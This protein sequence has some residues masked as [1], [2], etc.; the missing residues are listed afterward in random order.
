MDDVLKR[1]E[2][3]RREFDALR[4]S[5]TEQLPTDLQ[6]AYDIEITYASNAIEG[7]SLTLGET[8]E[9]IEHGTTTGNKKLKD[10]LEATDHFEAVQ[11]MRGFAAT[12]GAINEEAV[13]ELHRLTMVRSRAD[14]AGMYARQRRRVAGSPMVF[15]NW[16]KVPDLVKDFGDRIS[17]ANGAPA[18]AFDAHSRLVTIHPFSDGNGRTARLLANLMLI[19]NGYVTVSV[20]PDEW[21]EYLETIKEAQLAQDGNAPAFQAFMHRRLEVSLERHVSDLSDGGEVE[22]ANKVDTGKSIGTRRFDE[23]AVEPQPK[24]AATILAA[25]TRGTKG[26]CMADRRPALRHPPCD[27]IT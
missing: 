25:D 18:S 4:P 27:W 12:T 6:R 7:N 9:V 13:V 11:W 5:G 8:A 24:R 1:L 19:R 20:G 14:I 23:S 16:V 3:L 10:Y 15:P 21:R 26:Q 17:H 22:T 2:R